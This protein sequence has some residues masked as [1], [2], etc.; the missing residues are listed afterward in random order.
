MGVNIL[1]VLTAMPYMFLLAGFVQDVLNSGA[2]SLGLL[3]SVSGIGALTGALVIASMPGRN[4]GAYYLL[5]SAFQGLMLLLAFAFSNSV[6]MM[7]AFMVL[8]GVGQSARQSLSN[9]LVQTYV[10]EEY[11]GRVMSVYMLQFSLS[12][13]GAFLTG[14]LAAAMGPRVALGATSIALMVV[15]LGAFAFIPRLRHLQ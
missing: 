15:A 4:R 5:G 3:Q 14:V 2:D 7:G 8:M 6:L 9:V 13:F 10:D 12:Q 1:V 11:R